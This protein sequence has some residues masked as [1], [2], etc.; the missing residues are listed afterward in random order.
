MSLFLVG[1]DFVDNRLNILPHQ[2][3]ETF[4]GG[5]SYINK[6]HCFC[7]SI[8]GSRKQSLLN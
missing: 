7:F 2:I 3:N 1:L 4:S 8:N 5:D 6:A